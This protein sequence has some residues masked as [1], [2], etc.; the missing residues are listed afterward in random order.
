[1]EVNCQVRD[2]RIQ[3]NVNPVKTY[4]YE[5]EINCPDNPK[6]LRFLEIS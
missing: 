3:K 5:F 4:Y 6:F 2:S 1:M